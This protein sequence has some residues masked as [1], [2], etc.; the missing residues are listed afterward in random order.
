[1]PETQSFAVAR[2]NYATVNNLRMYHEIHGAGQPL[3]VLHGAGGIE[4]LGSNL[5][6]LAKNRKVIAVDYQAH[7]PTQVIA[8]FAPVSGRITL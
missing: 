4:M 1:M 7:G 2:G 3:V 5:E 6:A 8:P